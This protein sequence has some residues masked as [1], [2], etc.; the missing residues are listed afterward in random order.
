MADQSRFCCANG[1]FAES[2]FMLR[3]VP[4][5]L[6]R[7]D[8]TCNREDHRIE[9]FISRNLSGIKFSYALAVSHDKFKNYLHVAKFCPQ[10]TQRDDSKYLSSVCF[11]LRDVWR[12][13]QKTAGGWWRERGLRSGGC[14]RF[15]LR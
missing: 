1:D 7:F 2:A 10:L 14:V 4:R 11:Y 8:L 6:N 9:Y 12:I 15:P 5:F 3:N 13:I